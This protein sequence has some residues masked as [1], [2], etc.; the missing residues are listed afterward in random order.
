MSE[1]ALLTEK[2]CVENQEAWIEHYCANISNRLAAVS[3]RK[4][5]RRRS[6]TA[7]RNEL[8]KRLINIKRWADYL[9]QYNVVRV[10]VET[11]CTRDA[12]YPYVTTK[13]LIKMEA[14]PFEAPG[15][16][17]FWDSAAGK[18]LNQA[19]NTTTRWYNRSATR[20]YLTTGIVEDNGTFTPCSWRHYE[21]GTVKKEHYAVLEH[22][23]PT[24]VA[25]VLNI[26][27]HKLKQADD[28]LPLASADKIKAGIKLMT[29]MLPFKR[30]EE[31]GYD[32]S[33]GPSTSTW[34]NEDN[35]KVIPRTLLTKRVITTEELHTQEPPAEVTLTHDE[36]NREFV[37]TGEIAVA[38]GINVED[39]DITVDVIEEMSAHK[40]TRYH[41]KSRI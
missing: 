17:K 9:Q 34:R 7:E 5:R 23:T 26:Q 29:E 14:P 15:S 39:F 2:T 11:H 1:P 27:K 22:P 12:V 36:A 31:T 13:F 33:F 41:T 28:R 6:I 18:F 37:A 25:K 35:F 40:L 16:R 3:G 19:Q 32:Y 4:L 8:R 30:A 20:T 10:D 24:F 38:V 21:A